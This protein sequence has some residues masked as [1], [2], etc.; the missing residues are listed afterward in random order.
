M[1]K[2]LSCFLSATEICCE[3]IAVEL[4]LASLEFDIEVQHSNAYSEEPQIF[5]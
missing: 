2:L 4:R 1:Q 3:I 5:L